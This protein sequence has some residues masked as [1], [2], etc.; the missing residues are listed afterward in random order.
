MFCFLRNSY[1][2]RAGT[3]RSSRLRLVMIAAPAFFRWKRLPAHSDVNR[4]DVVRGGRV[5]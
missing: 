4:M 2:V 5:T 1:F 3:T